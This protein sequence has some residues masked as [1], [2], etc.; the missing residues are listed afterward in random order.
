MQPV[1]ESDTQ[2]SVSKI[3]PLSSG[4]LTLRPLIIQVHL[5]FAKSP[6]PITKPEQ[7]RNQELGPASVVDKKPLRFAFAL[8]VPG[9]QGLGSLVRQCGLTIRVVLC[10]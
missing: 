6:K 5:L 8:S 4:L 3:S 10:C 1:S 9:Y 7:A 2:V